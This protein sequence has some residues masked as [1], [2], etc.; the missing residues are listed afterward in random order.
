MLAFLFWNN[1]SRVGFAE[2]IN[3]FPEWCRKIA[4]RSESTSCFYAKFSVSCRSPDDFTGKRNNSVDSAMSSS[5]R[6]RDDEG[7]LGMWI[8]GMGENKQRPRKYSLEAH[9]L[10]KRCEFN[11]ILM[12]VGNPKSQNP[13][14]N[15]GGNGKELSLS[16]RDLVQLRCRGRPQNRRGRDLTTRLDKRL[17]LQAS[18]VLSRTLR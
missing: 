15:L 3:S 2:V 12:T 6:Q 11:D 16:S 8:P 4:S 9:S 5:R 13:S 10:G 14:L 1:D 7:G 18:W 17:C